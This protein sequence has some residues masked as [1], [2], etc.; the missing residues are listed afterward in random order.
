MSR[1]ISVGS[2]PDVD[3]PNTTSG[4]ATR[5]AAANNFCFSSSRS[6]ALSCT[7]WAPS[8]ASSTVVTI[9]SE[10]STGHGALV[11]LVLARRALAMTSPTLRGASG[12]GSNSTTSWPLSKNRAAQPPPITPP[13]S[14]PMWPVVIESPL[15]SLGGRE[16][17]P[18]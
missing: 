17:G 7:K 13:P 14:R 5:L 2:R 1:C 18:V 8:T 6:G 16:A 15:T 11:S 3:D 4:P 10:P 12:S 9:R